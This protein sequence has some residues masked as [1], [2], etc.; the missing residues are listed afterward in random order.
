VF[1]VSSKKKNNPIQKKIKQGTGLQL[2]QKKILSP[3]NV[4]IFPEQNGVLAFAKSSK[5]EVVV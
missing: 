3:S 5:K 4:Y 1:A 2:E